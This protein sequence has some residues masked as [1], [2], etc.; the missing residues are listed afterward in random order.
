MWYFL[1]CA[2]EFQVTLMQS[3]QQYHDVS[4]P[5][6][7]RRKKLCTPG[8][9]PSTRNFLLPQPPTLWIDQPTLARHLP[10]PH[11]P[12]WMDITGT[13]MDI[14]PTTTAMFLPAARSMDSHTQTATF[15]EMR[16]AAGYMP[17]L[18]DTRHSQAV[19][20][21]WGINHRVVFVYV[22]EWKCVCMCTLVSFGMDGNCICQVLEH[23]YIFTF[24]P[25]THHSSVQ[26]TATYKIIHISNFHCSVIYI[27]DQFFEKNIYK[28]CER[29]YF[30]QFFQLLAFAELFG[31]LI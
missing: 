4:F 10:L 26:F 6:E 27:W 16:M 1:R 29:P 31:S 14:R 20:V 18:G 9:P 15:T 5:D 21:G 12:P 11:G 7:D 22:S 23:I 13:L 28:F 17:T 3:F 24:T 19:E 30:L 2:G 8:H 25:F